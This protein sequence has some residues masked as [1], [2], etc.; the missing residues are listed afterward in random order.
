MHQPDAYLSFS[1]AHDR[2][3]VWLFSRRRR[4]LIIV[5][6]MVPCEA[7]CSWWARENR[8]SSVDALLSLAGNEE[9]DW[10]EIKQSPGLYKS[11]RFLTLCVARVMEACLSLMH[12][13]GGVV[14]V[15]LEPATLS[16]YNWTS[17]A[18][19]D[20]DD[21]K[22]R[23]GLLKKVRKVLNDENERVELLKKVR[24][25]FV[26]LADAGSSAPPKVEDPHQLVTGTQNPLFPTDHVGF[27]ALDF[28]ILPTGTGKKETG[29]GHICP[30]VSKPGAHDGCGEAKSCAT[31]L[32][33]L[34]A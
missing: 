32:C 11:D 23:A 15:G 8:K 18:R 13:C 30:P 2:G 33:D 7:Q 1:A 10:L 25:S 6:A 21:K 19:F 26:L 24:R 27:H 28:E 16:W 9:T 34:L 29:V 14:L 3:R 17:G 20:Q 22:K 4:W 12:W 5:V 31:C